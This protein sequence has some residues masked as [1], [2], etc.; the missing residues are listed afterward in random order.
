[1]NFAKLTAPNGINAV[2]KT[3]F[4]CSLFALGLCSVSFGQVG[5]GNP[6]PDS[7]SV[8]DLTNPNN[9]G[10]VLPPAPSTAAFSTTSTLG[11]TYFTNG[12]IFYKR[13][14]GY[15]ALTPWRYK[16]DGNISEDVYYNLG[17]NIGI[18]SS[19]LTTSPEAPLHIETDNGID[20][21]TNG[22]LLI[23]ISSAAN[24]AMNSGEIQ[25]RSVGSS[26]P[27]KINEDGGDVTFGSAPSPVDVA[28]A[29]KMQELHQPTG[30][31]FDLVPAGS[32]LMWYGTPADVPTG[33]AICD[34]GTYQRSDNSGTITTPD[35]SG[36]FIVGAGTNGT[37]T[38]TAHDAG[39]QDS[40]ALATPELPAHS[41]YLS[42]STSTTGSHRH[43]MGGSFYQHDGD[44]SGGD[45]GFQTSGND[46]TSSAGN[47]NHSVS[48][49]TQNTGSGDAHENRPAYHALVYILKL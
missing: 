12:N 9:R 19:S 29:G 40:V 3:I 38:Y 27:L 14:D 18:G 6:N 41:H 21:S 17:G 45:H 36:R 1:M 16:F 33:W 13:S 25:T 10:L 5:I 15:N 35:L 34:G 44:G 23:G 46:L 11:M 31:Y 39:G 49:N 42:L 32:I 48:G 4:A 43:G 8:L 24:L 2:K 7:T 37:S 30:S 26:A 28:A 47:H 20:L 22:S